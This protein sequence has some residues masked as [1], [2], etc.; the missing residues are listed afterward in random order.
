MSAEDYIK[1]CGLK[2]EEWTMVDPSESL[3][4]NLSISPD[5]IKSIDNEFAQKLFPKM[6]LVNKASYTMALDFHKSKEEAEKLVPEPPLPAPPTEPEF[7]TSDLYMTRVANIKFKGYVYDKALGMFTKKGCSLISPYQLEEMENEEYSLL[8]RPIAEDSVKVEKPIAEV[9]DIVVDAEEVKPVKKSKQTTDPKPTVSELIVK[10]SAK[11][12]EVEQIEEII[13]KS[14][15]ESSKKAEKVKKEEILKK[16]AEKL[17]NETISSE[18]NLKTE[19]EVLD[20]I[21]N[22]VNKFRR[23]HFIV[24]ELEASLE[25]YKNK[26]LTDSDFI[27]KVELLINS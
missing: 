16:K 4:K 6:V 14:V 10:S 23:N 11:S 2:P 25:D 1:L 8:L 27:E 3:F 12:P 22:L 26:H 19:F 5:N 13:P 15:I 9:K 18:N 7:P 20:T 21:G 24:R 17:K